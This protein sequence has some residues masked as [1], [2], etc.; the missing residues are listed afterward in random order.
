MKSTY[1]QIIEGEGFTMPARKSFKLACCDCGLVHEV[2]LVS[3]KD[4]KNIGVAMKINRRSTGQR[5]RY[6][7]AAK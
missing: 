4:R 1:D 2:A 5:R 6:M 7:K 3:S